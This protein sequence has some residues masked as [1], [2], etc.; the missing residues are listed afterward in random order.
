MISNLF[1]SPLQHSSTNTSQ[2]ETRQII[3]P[4]TVKFK[5]RLQGTFETCAAVNGWTEEREGL[6]L[7][8]SLRA[9]L[10]SGVLPSDKDQHYSKL[11]R[12]QGK[13]FPPL[14]QTDLYRMVAYL[15]CMSTYF[16]EK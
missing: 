11:V 9:Q 5:A 12:P 1:D 10:V 8:V 7:A 16:I 14:I 15:S 3:K 2:S 4:S 6:L 13:R